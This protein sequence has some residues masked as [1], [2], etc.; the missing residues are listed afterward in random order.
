[1]TLTNK[2]K[3][4][5]QKAFDT[6]LTPVVEECKEDISKILDNDPELKEK[7]NKEVQKIMKMREE[8]KKNTV[9]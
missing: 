4:S 7:V 8:R 5:F 9:I 6:I 3:E 1:M 2:E